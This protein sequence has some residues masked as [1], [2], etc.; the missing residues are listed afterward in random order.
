MELIYNKNLQKLDK[1]FSKLAEVEFKLSV[2]KCSFLQNVINYSGYVI[3]KSGLQAS[4]DKVLAI[5][6]IP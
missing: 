2:Q 1:R 3:N 6:N 4:P 5:K